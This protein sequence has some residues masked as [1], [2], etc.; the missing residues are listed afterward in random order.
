MLVS[1]INAMPII[2]EWEIAKFAF[3]QSQCFP[4]QSTIGGLCSI[5]VLEDRF[6]P[7]GPPRVEWYHSNLEETLL[8]L[9]YEPF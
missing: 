1:V 2:P 7:G 4:K 3:T 9:K 6:I 5:L 8:S